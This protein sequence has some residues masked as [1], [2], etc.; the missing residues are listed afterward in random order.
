[1]STSRKSSVGLS[2]RRGPQKA[3][4]PYRGDDLEHGK[5]TGKT[6]NQVSRDADDFEPF[7]QVLDQAYKS[8]NLP[9]PANK[10]SNAVNGH[11]HRSQP[12]LQRD[13]DDSGELSMDIDST[14]SSPSVYFK[15]TTAPERSSPGRVGS[16]SRPLPRASNVDYDQ[17]PSP[18]PVSRHSSTHSGGKFQPRHPS[19]LRKEVQ[20][21]EDNDRGPTTGSGR[22]I[23]TRIGHDHENTGYPG[24]DDLLE[25]DSPSPSSRGNVSFTALAQE[26]DDKVSEEDDQSPVSSRADKGKRRAEVQDFG[27]EDAGIEEE[28]AAGLQEIEDVYEEQDEDEP[29]PSRKKSRIDKDLSTSDSE[30]PNKPSRKVQPKRTKKKP[31]I[32]MYDTLDEDGLRRSKRRHY[33]PLEYWRQEKVV[34]GRRENGRSV[35]PV[36][37]EIIKIPKPDP[38]PL[39][40]QKR[41]R[42]GTRAPRSKSRTFTSPNPSVEPVG[43]LAVDNPE[44]GW[45]DDTHSNGIIL[46]WYSKTEVE[47]RVAYTAKMISPR[48]AQANKYSFQKV[49]GDGN[50]FAA[51]QLIIPPGEEKPPKPAKD[52]TYIFYVIEGA[53]ECK[54]HRASFVLATGGMFMVPRGNQYYIKNICKR[55]VKIFFAQARKI[56]E[57]DLEVMPE[58]LSKASAPSRA[59][60]APRLTSHGVSPKQSLQ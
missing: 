23:F 33:P 32:S 41:K 4:I 60:T 22:G 52:N 47:R 40:A 57:S 9:R 53:V 51:G 5:K 46:D 35:V 13:I 34:W 28:I 18:K 49:F 29:G 59:Q 6:V 25:N 56:E 2:S 16:L 48:A 55:E 30:P 7:E 54:V 11:S 12:P 39:R 45:D 19:R 1:M 10:K 20:D 37:K 3:H 31:R 15:N 44:I 36:I 24:G 50:F 14:H 17:V 43:V 8:D 27:E 42:A 38:E 26:D 58:I 21:D